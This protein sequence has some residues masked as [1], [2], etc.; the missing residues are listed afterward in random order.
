MIISEPRKLRPAI[1]VCPTVDPALIC[2]ITYESK[3]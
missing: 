3:I 2:I 1:G